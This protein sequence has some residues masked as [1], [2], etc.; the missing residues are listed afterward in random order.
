[1]RKN[2]LLHKFAYPF[3]RAYYRF[4]LRR[5]NFSTT[6]AP[7]INE[8][9]IVMSNHLTTFDTQLIW[10]AFPKHM[11]FVCGE[12]ILR[13]KNGNAIRHICDPITTPMGGSKLTATIEMLRR[14]K[15]GN[16]ILLYPEGSRSY[17][18]F[19]HPVS[20][21]TAK[22]VK[23]AKCALVTYHL[24]GGYVADP[25]WA[26]KSRSGKMEGKV[27]NVYSSEEI[28]KMSP[29]EIADHINTDI[30]ENAYDVQELNPVPYHS[31]SPAE[32]LEHYLII[33]PK[34]HGYDPLVTKGDQFTCRHCGLTGTYDEYGFLRSPDLPFNRIDKWDEWLI[35]YFNAD[36]SSRSDD[37]VLFTEQDIKL[38]TVV[39]TYHTVPL[40]SGTLTVYKDRMILGDMEMLFSDI[41]GMSLLFIGKTL[42]FT[43]KGTYYS[44]EGPAF[45]A[46]KVEML[47]RLYRQNNKKKN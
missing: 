46:R 11:Y 5:Y 16:N 35:P 40:T 37:E 45:Y 28:A 41:S 17:D 36:M 1:M 30:Y 18:G 42:L 8:P 13:G 7:A 33:C 21:S 24:R 19:T 3:L 29:E 22:L 15:N 38:D 6:V 34:C 26:F 27:V 14:I 31:D 44:M 4:A 32:G 23:R 2:E 39:Q 47:Y 43:Y 25:R 9:Y 20:V 10:Q 12:H